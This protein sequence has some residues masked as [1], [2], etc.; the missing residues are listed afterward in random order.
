MRE[1]SRKTV[2]NKNKIKK[3][4]VWENGDGTVVRVSRLRKDFIL[5]YPATGG[6]AER[7]LRRVVFENRFAPLR[8]K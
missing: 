6:G 8:E 2:E 7:K 5:F 4:S 3:G 1:E